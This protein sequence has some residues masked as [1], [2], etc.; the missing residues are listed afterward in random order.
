MAQNVS[1]RFADRFAT[2][3]AAASLT[4][5]PLASYA[6]ISQS[7]SLSENNSGFNSVPPLGGGT[8]GITGLSGINGLNASPG[9]SMIGS[10]SPFEINYEE[11]T[12]HIVVRDPTNGAIIIDTA[13]LG[14]RSYDKSWDFRANFGEQPL[15]AENIQFIA[16]PNGYDLEVTVSNAGADAARVGTIFAHGI[17]LAETVQYRSFNYF[18]HGD[19]LSQAKPSLTAWATG[20]PSSACIPVARL[21]LR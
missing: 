8:G 20:Y 2:V 10:H 4:F 17:R 12:G 1:I 7:S 3:I 6:Q 9:S 16:K 19:R 21:T 14:H 13:G 18:Q 5:A 11:Q 15:P